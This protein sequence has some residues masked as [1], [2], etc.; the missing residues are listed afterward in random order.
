[1]FYP[2]CDAWFGRVEGILCFDAPRL[3]EI[4]LA[5]QD[6]AFTLGEIFDW[7]LPL[8]VPGHAF[9]IAA[10]FTVTCLEND[11]VGELYQHEGFDNALTYDDPSSTKMALAVYHNGSLCAVAGANPWYEDLWR[12]GIDVLPEYRRQG[13]AVYLVHS[14][15]KTL[16]EQGVIPMY[17]TWYSNVGSRRT[18][19]KAGYLPVWVEIGSETNS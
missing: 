4:G 17:P 6:F 3:V 2:W 12:L 18:A 11:Q 9:T 10:H 13:I 15:T 7:Y 1:M 5:M 19:L 14:L 16:L 8:G